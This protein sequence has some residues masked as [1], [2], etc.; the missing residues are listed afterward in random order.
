MNQ[1]DQ[2]IRSLIPGRIRLRHPAIATLN[3]EDL[4]TARS[5]L[6]GL[7]GVFAVEFNPRVG[8]VLILW[9]ADEV[10]VSLFKEN[11]ENLLLLAVGMMAPTD[12]S[13][14]EGAP[15]CVEKLAH[16]ADKAQQGVAKTIGT[17][18]STIAGHPEK[19]SIKRV[20]RMALN[21]TMLGSLVVSLGGL[22][23]KNYGL[24]GAAGVLFLGLLGLHLTNNRHLL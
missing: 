17:V 9:N 13:A 18:A 6:E 15:T 10:P 7:D 3:A 20:E 23:F 12:E 1:F 16:V 14:Q 2:C 4:A 22:A 19:H 24:H 8:S 11:L 21:R 5:W